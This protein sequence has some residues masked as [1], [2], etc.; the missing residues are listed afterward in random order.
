MTSPEVSQQPESLYQPQ[1]S[2]DPPAEPPS[3]PST[4][5]KDLISDVPVVAETPMDASQDPDPISSKDSNAITD[6]ISRQADEILAR[7]QKRPREP[8]ELNQEQQI[9]SDIRQ[10]QQFVNE[11]NQSI[12]QIPASVPIIESNTEEPTRQD[13]SEMLVVNPNTKPIDK[14]NEPKT[15]PMTDSPISSGNAARMDY[16]KLFDRL[17]NQTDD[18]KK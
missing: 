17:R 15:F 1:A 6:E 7:L 4:S 18:N 8:T 5:Q 14:K 9:L 16:E 10:Q 2:Q 3:D 13:D 11:S 12:E